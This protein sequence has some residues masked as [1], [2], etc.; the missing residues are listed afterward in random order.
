L[1]A[2]PGVSDLEV[3]GSE[4]SGVVEGGPG[5]LLTVLA[6]HPVDHLLLPE[7]DLEQAFLRFYEEDGR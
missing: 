7:P 1:R 5:G 4:V 3:R 2:T 6:R